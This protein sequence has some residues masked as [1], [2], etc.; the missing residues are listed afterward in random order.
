MSPD[1]AALGFTL[2]V[3]D[4]AELLS[5]TRAETLDLIRA[6]DLP[7]LLLSSPTPMSPATFLLHVDEVRALAGRMESQELTSDERIR[8]LTQARLR[9]YLAACPPVDDY[10]EAIECGHPLWGRVLGGRRTLNVRADAIRD[11]FAR[12]D[13]LMSMTESSIAMTL[14]RLGGVKVRGVVP[15]ATVGGKQR[16]AT[17]YRIPQ[18]LLDGDSEDVL[19]RDVTAGQREPGEEVRRRPGSAPMVNGNPW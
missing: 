15:W 12:I 1:Y 18:S 2:T 17:M 6:R 10:D 13:P 7:S 19:V 8:S 9:D 4:A 16:W 5:L 14:E 3:N 11:F